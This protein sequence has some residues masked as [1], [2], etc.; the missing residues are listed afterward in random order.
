M[1]IVP[2]EILEAGEEVVDGVVHL[3]KTALHL[4]HV[5]YQTLVL[6]ILDI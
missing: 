4:S 6:V 5:M 1:G 2:H 3:V